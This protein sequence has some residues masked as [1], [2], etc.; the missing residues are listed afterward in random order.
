MRIHNTASY[1]DLVLASPIR[2]SFVKQGYNEECFVS[3]IGISGKLMLKVYHKG[4]FSHT[5]VTVIFLINK[6]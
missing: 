1:V 3:K 2:C 6:Y 5:G 4:R